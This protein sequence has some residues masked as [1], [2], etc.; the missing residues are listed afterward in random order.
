VQGKVKRK[1]ASDIVL[2]ELLWYG[3]MQKTRRQIYDEL[4]GEGFEKQYID[5]YIFCLANHQPMK[6]EIKNT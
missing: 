6:V 1:L 2:S 4:L 5:Y 3:G